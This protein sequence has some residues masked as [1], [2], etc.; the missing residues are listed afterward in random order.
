MRPR[1][2]LVSRTQIGTSRADLAIRLCTSQLKPPLPQDPEQ[3]R[4]FGKGPDKIIPKAPA[5][6]ENLEIK[7]PFPWERKGLKEQPTNKTKQKETV[8]TELIENKI[9]FNNAIIF[10]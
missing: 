1:T 5:P 4:G 8:D 7:F 2:E 3:I 6:G 9:Y 10:F